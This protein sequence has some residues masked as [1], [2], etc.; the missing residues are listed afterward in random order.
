MLISLGRA[1]YHVTAACW[2]VIALLVF[3]LGNARAQQP[4]RAPLG[5]PNDLRTAEEQH[6][7]ALGPIAAR[8]DE[9]FRIAKTAYA[10][11]L[12][13][14][15]REATGRG[16]LDTA[17]AAKAER[18]A[19]AAAGAPAAPPKDLPKALIPARQRFDQAVAQAQ[20]QSGREE[21]AQTR[22]YLAVLE[23]L[24][25]R[26]T[27]SGNLEAAAEI[28][29]RR[30]AVAAAVA[31]LESGKGAAPL[32]PLERTKAPAPAALPSATP[33]TGLT[34]TP[35]PVAGEIKAKGGV[36]EPGSGTVVFDAP[37]GDGRSGARGILLKDDAV[38]AAAARAGS[39]WAFRYQRGGSARGV[40]MIHPAG[41]GQA[42]AVLEEDGVGIATP[43]AWNELGYGG[44][45]TKRIRKT[46]AFDKIFPLQSGVEYTVVSRL[47]PG[48][49]YE[50]FLNGELVATGRASSASP[51]NLEIPEG[52]SFPGAGRG[53]LE[54]KGADGAIL[55]M[56]WSAGWAGVL[57]GPL[58]RGE[59]VCRDLRFYPGVADVGVVKR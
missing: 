11:A 46:N 38:A 5:V 39:T 6:A 20:A 3:S 57:L 2:F 51:L 12:D 26:I 17:L 8:R 49:A 55:P 19:L 21:A 4:I 59:N 48:G 18:E 44:G 23:A 7:A 32:P 40:Q 29:E 13:Q 35:V 31:A 25:T 22:T 24:Q 58:D 45:D 14:L 54:F 43:E 28:R 15:Q 10:T 41:R 34:M 50:L 30:T 9:R 16:D 47:S 27:K 56:K 42:I 52:R 37:R 53:N 1:G 33:A 36:T